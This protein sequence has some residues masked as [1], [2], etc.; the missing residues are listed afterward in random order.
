ML[1]GACSPRKILNLDPLRLLLTQS[2]TRL[3]SQNFQMGNRNKMC[4]EI[5]SL[6][7]KTVFYVHMNCILVWP[8]HV[9]FDCCGSAHVAVEIDICCYGN[10]NAWNLIG[11]PPR[12]TLCVNLKV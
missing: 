3:L 1:V 6:K 4:E 7:K 2:G 8:I 12:D 9:R 11:Q 10:S 5:L